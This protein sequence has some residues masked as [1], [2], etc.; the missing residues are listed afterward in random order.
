MAQ[1]SLKLP[2]GLLERIGEREGMT[3]TEI[4]I[5]LL[6]RGL[7][8]APGLEV[9]LLSTSQIASLDQTAERWGM[10]RVEAVQRILKERIRREWVDERNRQLFSGKRAPRNGRVAA[11]LP[12]DS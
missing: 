10:T 9:L 4:V 1:I 11:T 3:R 6:G 5:E 8:L 7:Q 12:P 2:D